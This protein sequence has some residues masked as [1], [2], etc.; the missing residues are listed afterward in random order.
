MNDF[1]LC[2][3]LIGFFDSLWG[4]FLFK[5]NYTLKTL[6]WHSRLK[7]PPPLIFNNT[8]GYNWFLNVDLKKK[9]IDLLFHQFYQ[10]HIS[11]WEGVQAWKSEKGGKPSNVHSQWRLKMKGWSFETPITFP[12][13]QIGHAPSL[14]PVIARHRTLSS[15][16]SLCYCAPPP[17][18]IPPPPNPT[19]WQTFGPFHQRLL[20][21]RNHF[22]KVNLCM[23][24]C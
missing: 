22:W 24:V 6:T 15:A 19:P 21:R 11:I 16:T 20:I 7:P 3:Q 8:G 1:F 12:H 13:Y 10:L 17:P 5:K 14:H 9:K 23:H 4:F 18:H 2:F